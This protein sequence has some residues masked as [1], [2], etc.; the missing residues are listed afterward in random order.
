[1]WWRR[2]EGPEWLLWR[3]QG[4]R[5][6]RRTDTCVRPGASSPGQGT[7][8]P[9]QEGDP[10]PGRALEGGTPHTGGASWALARPHPLPQGAQLTSPGP[11]PAS[12]MSFVCVCL[13]PC[14]TPVPCP[15]LGKTEAPRGRMEPAAQRSP[16]P[17][18]GRC[19][20]A[21]PTPSHHESRVQGAAGA[22]PPVFNSSPL[23]PRSPSG[24][25]AGAALTCPEW[26][27]SLETKLTLNRL[28]GLRRP[29]QNTRA[30]S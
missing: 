19:P 17:G 1:M 24:P 3:S 23:N 26:P 9:W 21:P 20:G 30:E 13:I 28:T 2:R 29:S 6:A 25:W 5:P 27:P 10:G 15:P 4:P 12:W 8:S 16:T 14:F 11:H 22:G 7:L 18:Q